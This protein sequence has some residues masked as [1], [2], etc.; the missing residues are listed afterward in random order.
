MFRCDVGKTC[1]GG[2]AIYPFVIDLDRALIQV[3]TSNTSSEVN[4]TSL[5]VYGN[6]CSTDSNR[7]GR[8][9][10]YTDFYQTTFGIYVEHAFYN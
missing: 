9:L 8:G 10:V 3:D 2:L 4:D 1:R 7:T 6:G 5:I